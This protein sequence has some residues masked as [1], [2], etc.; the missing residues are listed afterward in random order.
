MNLGAGVLT[1][2]PQS[3]QYL[4]DPAGTPDVYTISVKVTDKDNADVTKTQAITVNN[5]APT[6]SLISPQPGALIA[7]NTPLPFSGSFTDPGT[8]DTHTAEWTFTTHSIVSP[9]TVICSGIVNEVS[10]T[11][12]VA[13]NCPFT[14]AGI[15]YITLEVTDDDNGVGQATT[16]GT[17]PAYV[18]VYDPSGGFVTG[19]G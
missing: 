5:V 19:G 2:V 17:D 8:A 3:H 13:D 14:Q 6:V 15:Y 18:V 11:V 10:D 4:D 7:V 9:D 16:I 1:F 12:M